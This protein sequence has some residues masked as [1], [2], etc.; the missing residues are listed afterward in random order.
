MHS[1]LVF[2]LQWS[3]VE[4]EGLH[5]HWGLDFDGLDSPLDLQGVATQVWGWNSGYVHNL[6]SGQGALGFRM[7]A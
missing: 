1:S 3:V 4:L 2:W 5:L 6:W 7:L